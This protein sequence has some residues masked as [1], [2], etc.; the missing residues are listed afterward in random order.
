MSQVLT[1]CLHLA[2][3]LLSIPSSR[4]LSVFCC[5]KL[6]SRTWI[7]LPRLLL[8]M[9]TSTPLLLYLF[10]VIEAFLWKLHDS[11]NETSNFPFPGVPSLCFQGDVE[12]K[13]TLNLSDT[14]TGNI[15][16]CCGHYAESGSHK[17]RSKVTD[18]TRRLLSAWVITVPITE[19]LHCL[20]VSPSQSS[21]VTKTFSKRHS[22]WSLAAR[23]RYQS[24]WEQPWQNGKW[25]LSLDYLTI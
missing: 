11:S 12:S 16:S 17:L 10:G 7:T 21:W 22:S 13:I 4:S 15:P 2:L 14:I 1:H 23:V 20:P 24:G 9:K 3:S 25:R 18:R 19:Q 8:P 5:G 6:L